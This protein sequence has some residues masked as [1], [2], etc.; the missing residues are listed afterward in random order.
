MTVI[1]LTQATLRHLWD[2]ASIGATK[3]SSTNGVDYY[4]SL[5]AFE[6]MAFSMYLR[7]HY[8]ASSVNSDDITGCCWL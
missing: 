6:L 1:R 5:F 4:S 2:K 7:Y 3:F 8:H